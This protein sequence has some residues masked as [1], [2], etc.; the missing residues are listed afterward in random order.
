MPA[1]FAD[2]TPVRL[3]F[4]PFSDAAPRN[5]SLLFGINCY[6]QR[7]FNS[8]NADYMSSFLQ[9][10]NYADGFCQISCGRCS[11]CTDPAAVLSKLGADK[12]LQA[13]TAANA[14]LDAALAHP[15]FMA[16]LLVPN[17]A[18]WDAALSAYPAALKDPSLLLEVLKFHILPPEPVRR[19]LWTSPFMAVGATLYTA[20]DGPATLTVPKFPLPKDTTAYGGLSGFSINGPVNSAKVLTSDI[21]TCKSY[22]N[23]IDTVLLPFDPAKASANGGGNALGSALGASMCN[24]A[25]SASLN[26]SVIK[27]GA[28][29]RQ[30]SVGD[31]CASCHSDSNCNAFRYCA[32]LGGCTTADGTS[33]PFGY[34]LLQ[35]SSEVAAGAGPAYYDASYDVPFVSGY[36]GGGSSVAAAGR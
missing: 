19:G 29:N 31:C 15:G 26:G 22:I 20:A 6:H 23:V 17:D 30:H 27:D 2:I 7:T 3:V 1:S 25:G 11:C 21:G 16:T 33:Y 13:V 34:C 4:N 5:E 28:S 10:L 32:L 14:S 24:L 36:I 18:A 12:F 35:H 8:C 9:E